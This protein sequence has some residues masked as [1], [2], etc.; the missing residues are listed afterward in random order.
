MLEP[1]TRAMLPKQASRA[2]KQLDL[3]QAILCLDTTLTVGIIC[4]RD[5]AD[6]KTA[7]MLSLMAPL[8]C[9]APSIPLFSHD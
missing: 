4:D 8:P 1:R 5:A 3:Q 9:P 6:R 2:I 7:F